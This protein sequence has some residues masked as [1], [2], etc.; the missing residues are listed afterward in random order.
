MSSGWG[1]FEGGMNGLRLNE[2]KSAMKTKLVADLFGYLI[3]K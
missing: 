3:K 1:G 2:R